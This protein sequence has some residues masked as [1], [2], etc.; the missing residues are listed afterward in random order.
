M[1]YGVKGAENLA[2]VIFAVI[3]LT[4]LVFVIGFSVV[5]RLPDQPAPIK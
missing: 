5:G 3:V 2:P 1:Q 4:V